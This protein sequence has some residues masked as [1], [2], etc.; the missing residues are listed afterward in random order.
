MF[1]AGTFPLSC[2]LKNSGKGIRISE[3]NLFL[4]KVI[5]SDGVIKQ[6]RHKKFL[7]TAGG[8]LPNNAHG[9]YP[10]FFVFTGWSHEAGLTS[11]AERRIAICHYT[12]FKYLEDEIKTR[13]T[14][15]N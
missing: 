1:W 8:I 14:L 12:V 10:L 7:Q 4:K 5:W 11:K 15:N 3:L 13:D 9:R 2:S 6:L